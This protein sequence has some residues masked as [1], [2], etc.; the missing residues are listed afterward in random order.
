M[1]SQNK[2]FL[3]FGFTR[4]WV[5][6]SLSLE[7]EEKVLCENIEVEYEILKPQGT[8]TDCQYRTIA[9]TAQWAAEN[10]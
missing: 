8:A 6:V 10:E 2:Y 4:L 5:L 7:S 3:R 1:K 9:I